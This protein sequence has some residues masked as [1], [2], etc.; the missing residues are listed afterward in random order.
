MWPLFVH[1]F[2]DDPF[3]WPL[4]LILLIDH[5]DW[6]CLL[7][8][9]IDIAYWPLW[10]IYI[11]L[12]AWERKKGNH[13][14]WLVKVRVS[15]LQSNLISSKI[16]ILFH[17]SEIPSSSRCKMTTTGLSS[18]KE[19]SFNWYHPGRSPTANT[20]TGTAE[21]FVSTETQSSRSTAAKKPWTLRR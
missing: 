12:I 6:Y 19:T 20:V 10:Y 18:M 5:C 17:L 21:R 1:K 7:T 9:V 14:V 16:I 4:W 11:L 8:I 15:R 2:G 13:K 3:Q